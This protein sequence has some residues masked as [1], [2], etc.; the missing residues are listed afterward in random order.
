M[1]TFSGL[2]TGWGDLAPDEKPEFIKSLCHPIERRWFYACRNAVRRVASASVDADAIDAGRQLAKKLWPDGTCAE[3]RVAEAHLACLEAIDGKPFAEADGESGTTGADTVV[4]TAAAKALDLPV[5]LLLDIE[6]ELRT[7]QP[8]QRVPRSLDSSADLR[9]VEIPGVFLVKEETP[10]DPAFIARLELELV[11]RPAAAQ[12][13]TGVLYSDARLAFV[14]R[15]EDWQRGP[16]RQPGH[17]LK[18]CAKRHGLPTWTSGG[19]LRLG[20][21]SNSPST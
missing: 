12:E 19:T 7:G 16:R 21:R 11:A 13:A 18:R 1:S 5:P 9:R 15:N 14:S 10:N 3:F 20:R 2:L 4:L 17:L 8:R 6:H